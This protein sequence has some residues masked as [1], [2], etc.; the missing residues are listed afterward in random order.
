MCMYFLG[1]AEGGVPEPPHQ[2]IR[3]QVRSHRMNRAPKKHL[4]QLKHIRIEVGR[5]AR[6]V[7]GQVGGVEADV[8]HAIGFAGIQ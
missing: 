7:G 1:A 5:E 2:A 4:F 8:K 6:A 3:E